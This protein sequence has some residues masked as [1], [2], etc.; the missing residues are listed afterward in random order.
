MV[1]RHNREIARQERTIVHD[2]MAA[3][4][5]PCQH[6]G[7]CWTAGQRLAIVSRER[8]AFGREGVN[9]SCPNTWVARRNQRIA[10]L[11]VFSI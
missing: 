2:A 3:D 7:W 5:E 9:I 6:A 10:A 4:R 1:A 11:L 8:H